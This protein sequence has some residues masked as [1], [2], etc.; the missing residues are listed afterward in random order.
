[1]NEEIPDIE[2][3]CCTNFFARELCSQSYELGPFGVSCI[4]VCKLARGQKKTHSFKNRRCLPLHDGNSSFLCSTT[5]LQPQPTRQLF[6]G[7]DCRAKTWS[8][9]VARQPE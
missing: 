7:D 6:R 1:M 9:L 5:S 3:K 8:E 2:N 4:S